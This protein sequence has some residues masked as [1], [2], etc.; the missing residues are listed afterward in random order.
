MPQNAPWRAFAP[1]LLARSTALRVMLRSMSDDGNSAKS[2]EHDD[3][4]GD[5]H[6]SKHIQHHFDGAQHQFDSAKLGV[7]AFLAQ[8]V[9][10]F[11][12]LFVAYVVYR[13]THPEAVKYASH[14][15]DVK[16]GAINTVVLI[17]S[18]LSAAWAVRAAQLNQ[19]KLLKI[20]LLTT[21]LCAFGF[22]GIKYTEYSHK[23]HIGAVYGC[24]FN[25]SEAGDG[26]AMRYKIPTAVK[27]SCKT[28][29]GVEMKAHP[30]PPRVKGQKK[31]EAPPEGTAMFF[32]IY[33]A[34]T[35]LHGIHVIA[36]ILLFSWLLWRSFKGHFTP[37]Y[38]SP[39]DG[40]ALYWHI[41]D[42]IWI[43]LFPL[44]YL[45]H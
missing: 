41:V 7:W 5:H 16:L 35:G 24:H 2:D 37:E 9:M 39:I 12:G 34:M 44:L 14:Y 33:F 28:N 11:S 4:H 43:F 36:G 21:I 26:R 23:F 22:L 17:F 32:T 31:V 13:S 29:Y 3:H 1:F 10:F 40:A 30:R 15:L 18:S 25:P 19:Q 6:G 42:L 20:C 38:F 27:E 45:I 8:E